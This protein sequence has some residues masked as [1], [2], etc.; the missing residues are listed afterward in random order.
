MRAA[1]IRSL[2]SLPRPD[3]LLIGVP[4]LLSTTIGNPL[5]RLPDLLAG[6][7]NDHVVLAALADRGVAGVGAVRRRF[8]R[9]VRLRCPPHPD[10]GPDPGVFAVQQGLARALINGALLLLPIT[11]RHRRTGRAG[12]GDEATATTR[13]RGA[14]TTACQRVRSTAA[15]GRAAGT[16]HRDVTVTEGGARTWWDLAAAAPRRRRG[17]AAAVGPQPG[18][19]AGRRHHA[20]HRT[21]G[22]ADPAGRPRPRHHRDT[23]ITDV[24]RTVGPHQSS[25]AVDVTVEAGDT[26]SADR[27]RPRRQRLDQLWPA[28][29]G[30]AEPDGDAAHRPGL[31]RTRLAD[32]H[33]RPTDMGDNPTTRRDA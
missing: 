13:R 5:D 6:D 24:G 33:P 14:V 8:R 3:A 16:R 28:N 22:A 10:A 29:A 31:H 18:P 30:R 2:R 27:R 12:R 32:H 1:T 25:A 17:V 11:R 7:V 4:W 20:D 21:G 9:R 19:G 15:A 26:L 23:P